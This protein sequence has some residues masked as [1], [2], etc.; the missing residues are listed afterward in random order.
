MKLTHVI[1]IYKSMFPIK[2]GINIINILYAGSHTQ[3][4]LCVTAY[5]MEIFK[6]HFKIFI[7]Y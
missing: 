2:K 6:T 3:K 1:Q 5:R 7:L 4:K